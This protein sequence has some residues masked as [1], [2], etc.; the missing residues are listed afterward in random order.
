M[1]NWQ[2]MA[3]GLAAA[4]AA[5]SAWGESGPQQFGPVTCSDCRLVTPQPDRSTST[6]LKEFYE[7]KYF[8]G[9]IGLGD[10]YFIKP[11]DRIMVCN[12][13]WCVNYFLTQDKKWIGGE[14]KKKDEHVIVKPRRSTLDIIKSLPPELAADILREQ[15][16]DR[17]LNRG[18][19][20]SEPVSLVFKSPIRT[21]T[22]TVGPIDQR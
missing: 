17:L 7:E 21:G 2:W 4:G 20:G 16:R 22:V 19:K 15:T 6:A 5:Y 3:L 11:G 12:I 8:G 18:G 1:K 14:A 13:N 10:K 9:T